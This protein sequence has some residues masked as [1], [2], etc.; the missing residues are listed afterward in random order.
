MLRASPTAVLH[1]AVRSG[2][3][4]SA[5]VFSA[6]VLTACGTVPVEPDSGEERDS[7]VIDAPDVGADTPDADAQP[8][9]A[10]PP[11][12]EPVQE[13]AVEAH[14]GQIW[15]AGGIENAIVVATVRIFDPPTGVWSLGPELPAPRHHMSLVAHDGA[16]Y[17]I[18]GMQTFAFEPLDTA[19]VLRDASATW[20]P[21]ASLPEDRGAGAADSVGDTIVVAGGNTARG[22]LATNTLIYAPA[23][24]RWSLGAAIPTPREHLAAVA[25][26]AELYV[27]GGRFNSIG[28]A[29]TAVEIYDPATD[30]WRAGPPLIETRGGFDATLLGETI[31]AVGGEVSSEALDSV[32][33]LDIGEIAW[34]EAPSTRAPHHGHGVVTLDGRIWVVAG[35]DAPAF[36]AIATVESYAP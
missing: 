17:A 6:A 14:R 8:W 15:L 19:W 7:H 4:F 32:E 25:V 23:D 11:V 24:D 20:E 12:P 34:R 18:G 10:E 36:A 33:R 3:V 13:I 2:A 22:M 9:R 26:D 35:G 29:I 5:A 28:S 1:P 31:F 30:A 16:L 21:I 27:L